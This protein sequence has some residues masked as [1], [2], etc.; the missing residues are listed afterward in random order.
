M[1]AAGQIGSAGA[2]L[3]IGDNHGVAIDA[4]ES[5]WAHYDGTPVAG[6]PATAQ[7][8]ADVATALSRF[9][10][11]VEDAKRKI[12]NL[13]I[14]I[15][16]TIAVG[17]GMAIFSFGTSAGLAAARTAMLVARGLT[18]AL[19]LSGIA[20]TIAATMLVGAAFGA[21]EGF[22]GS[23]VAQVAE[24]VLPD[25]TGISLAKTMSWTGGGAVGG[26]V[27]A[28]AG[29]AVRGGFRALSQG[30]SIVANRLRAIRWGDET[31]SI[32]LGGGR[33]P[34][35]PERVAELAETAAGRKI[36][37]TAVDK[38]SQTAGSMSLVRLTRKP[39]R[40]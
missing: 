31:G 28:G 40:P 18:V 14:E 2:R 9:A 13:A 22:I 26:A 16:A 27:F 23:I 7:A 39:E 37:L 12:I 17:I 15:G 35:P 32:G 29:L 10:R 1:L 8:A 30:D 3:V 6:L 21:V 25:G 24:T 19:G 11:E 36:R 20:S 34:R 33:T 38:G 5:R 4:F